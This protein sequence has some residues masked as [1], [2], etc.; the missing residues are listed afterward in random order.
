MKKFAYI[1]VLLLAAADKA[2]AQLPFEAALSQDLSGFGAAIPGAAPE[3]LLPG[4]EPGGGAAGSF[5]FRAGEVPGFYDASRENREPYNI[6]EILRDI[7][8]MWFEYFNALA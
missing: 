8:G 5:V 1:L 2:A 4:R 3:I 7:P 6:P